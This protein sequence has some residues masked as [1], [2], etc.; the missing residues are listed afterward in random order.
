MTRRLD[1][2]EKAD[3]Q[4]LHSSSNSVKQQRNQTIINESGLYNAII[5]S[6]KPI[7]QQRQLSC[8]NLGEQQQCTTTRL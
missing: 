6:K 2:D 7:N 3:M 8:A 1:D 4:I 5:G